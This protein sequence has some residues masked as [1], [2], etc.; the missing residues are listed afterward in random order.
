[1]YVLYASLFDTVLCKVTA[2]YENGQLKTK[3]R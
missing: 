2:G 3:T 1:M